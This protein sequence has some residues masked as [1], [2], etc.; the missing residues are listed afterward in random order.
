MKK[1]LKWLTDDMEFLIVII[2]SGIYFLIFRHLPATS[3]I[4]GIQLGFEGILVFG[5]LICVAVF[6]IIERIKKYGKKIRIM[7]NNVMSQFPV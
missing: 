5:I 7:M 3:L 6:L 2:F 4:L 1:F